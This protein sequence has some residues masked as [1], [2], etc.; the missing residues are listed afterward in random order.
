MV[1][2]EQGGERDAASLPAGESVDGGL[3]VEVAQESRHDVADTGDGRPFVVGGVADHRL[4]DR[5]AG[6]E[7]VR[8]MQ[9]PGRHVAAAGH[10]A[11]IGFAQAREDRHER[12]LAVTVAT[13]DA[14]PIARVHTDR[15]L[16]ED[17][18]VGIA[19]ADRLC[20]EQV[21]RGPFAGGVERPPAYSSAGD[22]TRHRL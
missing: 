4:A 12:G 20:A 11:G 6:R 9:V 21:H 5:C 18:P 19:E 8:L 3:E 2:R 17:R 16:V 14:D 13:D 15:Q 10:A 22:G 1:T 7:V